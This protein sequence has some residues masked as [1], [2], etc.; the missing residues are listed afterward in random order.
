MKKTGVERI[1]V[2]LP[3]DL[4]VEFDKFVEERGYTNRSGA[5]GDAMRSVLSENRLED[6]Q[7]VGV[8]SFV[9]DHDVPKLA[10]R[11]VE[12]QHHF[13]EVVSSLHVHLSHDLC[14]E[15]IVVRGK[16]S[17]IQ[18]LSDKIQSM[19]GVKIVKASVLPAEIE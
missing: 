17:E 18:K 13:A 9:Y 14:A 11:L 19:R 7:G 1:S 6:G 15:I 10:E 2:S 3:A 8:V 4:L 16:S 5:I 12:I